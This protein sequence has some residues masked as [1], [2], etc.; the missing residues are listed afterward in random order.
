M[1][2]INA[3][4]FLVR[5]LIIQGLVSEVI[6]ECIL[7]EPWLCWCVIRFSSRCMKVFQRVV[8]CD[9][10]HCMLSKGMYDLLKTTAEYFEQHFENCNHVCGLYIF[11]T[12]LYK[13]LILKKK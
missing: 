13:N 2:E 11:F 12:I 4:T 5:I 10:D 6:Y 1:I 9:L 8:S 7:S 3:C